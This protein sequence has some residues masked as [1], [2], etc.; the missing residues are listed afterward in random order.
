M[1]EQ[2][3]LARC[4][5]ESALI[6]AAQARREQEH[7]LRCAAEARWEAEQAATLQVQAQLKIE[8]AAFAGLQERLETERLAES[9]ARE[10]E[11]ISVLKSKRARSRL[12]R[13]QPGPVAPAKKRSTGSKPVATKTPSKG[14][15]SAN[16]KPPTKKRAAN[17][18]EVGPASVLTP[19]KKAKP[20]GKT[21][22]AAKPAGRAGKARAKE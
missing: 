7:L 9:A 2:A 3:A 1:A 14:S 19:A 21:R 18:I 13:E 6:Q 22:S 11:R 15:G 20:P 16:Q 4:A 5:A 10:A 12:A 8:E 17:P